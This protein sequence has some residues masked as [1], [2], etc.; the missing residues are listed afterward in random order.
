LRGAASHDWQSPKDGAFGS[1]P[2]ILNARYF[3][4]VHSTISQLFGQIQG[5]AIKIDLLTVHNFY[6]RQVL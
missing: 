6:Q 1:K 3:D 4:F 5:H 2:S